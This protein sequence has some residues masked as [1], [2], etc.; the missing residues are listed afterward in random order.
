MRHRGHLVTGEGRGRV[1]ARWLV[2]L[3][4]GCALG[5]SEP[6]PKAQIPIGL[7]LSYSGTLAANSVNSERA[8]LMAIEATNAAGGIAGRD[9]A[10]IARDTRSAPRKV[11]PM[12]QALLDEKVALVIGPDTIALAVE[13]KALLSEQTLIMPS[14]TTSD[15]SIYKPR[16]WFVMGPSPARV[17]CEL[18]TQLRLAGWR[19]PVVPTDPN[20]FDNLLGRELAFSYGLRQVFLPADDAS[21]ETTVQP[22]VS[23]GADAFVLAALP[24]AATS[25]IYTLAALGQI[26]DAR[27]WYLSP[28]LHTPALLETIPHGLLEGA[29]GVKAGT[30]VGSKEFA[31]QFQRRW[32]D[33]PL[34]D[35][36]AFYDAGAIAVLALQR[37][38]VRDGAV[39]TGTG[40]VPH[41]IAVSNASGTPVQWNELGLG[42]E[43]LRQGQEVGYQGLSGPLDFDASGESAPANTTWWRIGPD[44]FE[45][46]PSQSDCRKTSR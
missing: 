12:A 33:K 11:T 6:G 25:L 15:S 17:A 19:A 29:H 41:V 42:L 30:V 26:G 8:L 32:Q 24:Q 7:L 38:L 22:I 3:V 27:R 34:D 1:R 4:W 37:A 45:D 10:V 20:G 13:L 2:T 14:F 40:L 43:L 21:N 9:V 23:V 28:T 46:V 18:Y 31:E 44:G 5:C 39:P 36:Y 16:S 35:A